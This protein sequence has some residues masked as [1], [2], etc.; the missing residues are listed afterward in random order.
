MDSRRTQAEALIWPTM[1]ACTRPAVNT[2]DLP[3]R[4]CDSDTVSVGSPRLMAYHGSFSVGMHQGGL[5]HQAGIQ[6]LFSAQ[7]T[8]ATAATALQLQA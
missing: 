4:L 2:Y 6:V 8:A 3:S 5:H 7:P 1:A